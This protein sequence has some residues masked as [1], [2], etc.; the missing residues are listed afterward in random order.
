MV[1]R[2][3]VFSAEKESSLEA[4]EG[5]DKDWRILVRMQPS[6]EKHSSKMCTVKG[7]PGREMRN[8]DFW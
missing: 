1:I 7:T 6:D 2:I 5:L 3:L 4:S 8:S